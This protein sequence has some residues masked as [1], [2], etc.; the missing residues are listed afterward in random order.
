MI[1]CVFDPA[2]PALREECPLPVFGPMQVTLPL[3]HLIA[4]KFSY[5]ARAERQTQ[6]LAALAR[7][8]GYE[9]QLASARFLGISYQESRNPKI[10]DAAMQQQLGKAVTEDGAEAI[11]MGSTTMALGEEVAAAAG[12]VPVFL[13]GMVALG[14]METL[15]EN[16]FLKR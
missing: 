5:V 3:V 12:G 2:V 10:F 6:W 14:V 8:Y 4:N 13:P 9:A 1:D 7:Q 16:G 15:W 11:V